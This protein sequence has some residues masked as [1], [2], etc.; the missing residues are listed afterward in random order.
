M[1]QLIVLPVLSVWKALFYGAREALALVGEHIIL[2]FYKRTQHLEVTRN[3]YV[4]S[5]FSN[6]FRNYG[7]LCKESKSAKAHLFLFLSFFKDVLSFRM[8][9]NIKSVLV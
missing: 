6:L 3:E 8:K 1:R 7:R 2:H 9:Y 5:T 4:P